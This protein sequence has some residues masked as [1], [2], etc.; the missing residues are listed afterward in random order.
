MSRRG[1]GGLGLRT[2]FL[3]LAVACFAIVA[4]GINVDIGSVNFGGL[5]LAFFA[6]ALIFP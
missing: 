5:G 3:I 4:F 1:V 6:A 2:I